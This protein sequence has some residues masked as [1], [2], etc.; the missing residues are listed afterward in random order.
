MGKGIVVAIAP[1]EDHEVRG[2]L[3]TKIVLVIVATSTVAS[4]IEVL[5]AIAIGSL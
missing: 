4:I 1:I 5:R 2:G 3:R